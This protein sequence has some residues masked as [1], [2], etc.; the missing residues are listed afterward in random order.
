MEDQHVGNAKCKVNTVY[1]VNQLCVELPS[2]VY[3][4]LSNEDPSIARAPQGIGNITVLMTEHNPENAEH[5]ADLGA[6]N[7]CSPKSI[8]PETSHRSGWQNTNRHRNEP[9]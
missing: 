8:S 6:Q 7:T 3:F 4:L 9:L 5:A 2:L 1:R